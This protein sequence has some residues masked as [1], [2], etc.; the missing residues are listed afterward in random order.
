MDYFKDAFGGFNPR[1]DKDAA[2]KI[3]LDVILADQRFSELDNLLPDKTEVGG[4][5][6]E[7]GWI[8][9]R[10]NEG[11]IKWYENWPEFAR[12]R[13]FVDP[14]SYALAYPEFFCDKSTFE[15]FVGSAIRAYCDRHPERSQEVEPIL[16]KLSQ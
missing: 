13:A 3:C 11:E 16:H 8:I 5:E 12:F 10:R 9:E 7:P 4:M 15:K 1:T 2:L 6:G 14:S